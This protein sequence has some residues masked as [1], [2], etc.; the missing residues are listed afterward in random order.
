MHSRPA[1]PTPQ[2]IQI[3]RLRGSSSILSR[4]CP[5]GCSQLHRDSRHATRQAPGHPRGT[6]RQYVVHSKAR[7]RRPPADYVGGDHARRDLPDLGGAELWRVAEFR[8]FEVE[9]RRTHLNRRRDHID[10]T[11]HAFLADSL[12]AQHKAVRPAEH[13]LQVNGFC[14]RIVAGVVARMQID[15]F[16]VP[17]SRLDTEPSPWRR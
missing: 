3:W 9:H 13:Q 10:A 2:F 4:N 7:D 8:L 1:A 14:P 15:R 16:E 11:L 17:D 6:P 12:G 5:A